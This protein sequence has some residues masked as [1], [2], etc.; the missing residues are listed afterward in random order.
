MTLKRGREASWWLKRNSSRGK[1]FNRV[2]LPDET[3]L[4]L[5]PDPVPSHVERILPALFHS[6]FCIFKLPWLP[7]TFR[8]KS[9]F[10]MA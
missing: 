6:P 7:C 4:H 9:K 1:F 2:K 10:L 3:L 5:A 8:I